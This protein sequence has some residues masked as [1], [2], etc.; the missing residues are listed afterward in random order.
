MLVFL[1]ESVKTTKKIPQNLLERIVDPYGYDRS[2]VHTIK[3]IY[4]CN[5]K[6]NKTG[7]CCIHFNISAFLYRFIKVLSVGIIF[8]RNIMKRYCVHFEHA[9]KSV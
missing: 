6:C 2:H 5:W 3:P 7:D 4:T 1:T 9:F 8:S